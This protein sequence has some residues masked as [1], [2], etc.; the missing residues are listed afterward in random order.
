MK[1]INNLIL[2][3]DKLK[4]IIK[5]KIGIVCGHL[6]T[7]QFSEYLSYEILK[8]NLSN[9][10]NLRFRLKDKTFKTSNN[11]AMG[12]LNK[13]KLHKELN[14]AKFLIFPSNCYEGFP[15]ILLE[16][17]A[18]NTIVIAPNLGSIS[19]IIE[20]KYNGILF[21]P[22]DI[23]DLINKIKWV[24]KNDNECEKIKINAKK[25]L[26][27]K[28]SEKQNFKQLVDIYEAAIKENKNNKLFN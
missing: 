4:D 1:A 27:E 6:K 10:S 7:K 26:I 5:Y 14:S 9:D 13:E 24:L 25:V 28:Y 17:F 3:D 15:I 22:N 19:N 23:E 2:S 11:Y 16:A 18:F 8:K 20:D 21:K 12:F